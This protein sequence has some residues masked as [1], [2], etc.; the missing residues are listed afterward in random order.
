MPLIARLVNTLKEWKIACPPALDGK[1]KLVFPGQD[2]TPLNHS[3]LQLVFEDAQHQAKV[4]MK[5]AVQPLR[6]E[7]MR[8]D[9]REGRVL[10]ERAGG[11]A[12][13]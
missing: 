5:G 9:M 2:G 12:G 1:P 6:A 8:W 11:A 7:S 4:E 13:S 10:I 3:S